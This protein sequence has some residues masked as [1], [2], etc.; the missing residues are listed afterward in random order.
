MAKATKKTEHCILTK[1]V[2]T[3]P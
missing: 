3:S 2:P 1:K